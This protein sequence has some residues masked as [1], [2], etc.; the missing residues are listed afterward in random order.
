MC[1]ITVQPMLK[2]D[3]WSVYQMMFA[4]HLEVETVVAQA[5]RRKRRSM[6]RIG[7]PGRGVKCS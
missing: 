6:I 7:F 5:W 2:R 4:D 1:P 3:T